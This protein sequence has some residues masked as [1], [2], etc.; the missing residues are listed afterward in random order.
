MKWL[1]QSVLAIGFAIL[2]MS[3]GC[4]IN[5][6]E[7]ISSFCRIYE[8]VYASDQDT[9]ET[10]AGVDRNLAHWDQNCP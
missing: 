10:R 8:P 1:P 6:R 3:S 5:T 2:L 4:A 7:P 9:A